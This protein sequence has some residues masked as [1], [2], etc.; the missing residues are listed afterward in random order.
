MNTYMCQLIA[1]DVGDRTVNVASLKTE[2][3]KNIVDN[4]FRCNLIDKI[5]LFGSAIE[6][7]C[8]DDSDIDIAVF[9]KESK[10]KVFRSKE[11]RD[12]ID[13]VVS[14]GDL[15]DYDILF[16]D[17]TKNNDSAIMT[18]INKGLI[19]FERQ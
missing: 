13:S 7:R 14:F 12:Y 9:G 16:F 15:Q 10:N 11:Y 3:I 2:Y 18:D 5:V 4:V 19:L 1:L 6:E 8:T 17:T